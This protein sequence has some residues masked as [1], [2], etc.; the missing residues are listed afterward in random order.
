MITVEEIPEE[1]VERIIKLESFAKE[2][3]TIRAAFA[4]AIV[5]DL[6]NI[7]TQ[8]FDAMTEFAKSVNADD[9]VM[10]K[11][12]SLNY[13]DLQCANEMLATR[14]AEQLTEIERLKHDSATSE[15][16]ENAKTV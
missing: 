7:M 13:V 2:D 3:A 4:D 6:M 5:C 15:D 9:G 8:N 11:G 12:M 1:L 16:V 10:P 14:L